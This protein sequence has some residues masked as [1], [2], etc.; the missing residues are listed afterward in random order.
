[1]GATYGARA[2]APNRAVGMDALGFRCYIPADRSNKIIRMP[3]RR[4]GGAALNLGIGIIRDEPDLVDLSERFTILFGDVAGLDQVKTERSD[5][6]A[7]RFDDFGLERLFDGQQGRAR[8]IEHRVIGTIAGA[9]Q[10]G[11]IE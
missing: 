8:G 7:V 4:R 6:S 2:V 9:I 1:M 5:E 11:G 3:D 10:I